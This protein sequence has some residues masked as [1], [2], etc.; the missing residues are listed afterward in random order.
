MGFEAA[1]SSE[2]SEIWGGV[3]SVVMGQSVR[4]IGLPMS[5]VFSD[6]KEVWCQWR[7]KM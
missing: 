7:M 3:R 1:T 6:C 2:L 5:G 4:R